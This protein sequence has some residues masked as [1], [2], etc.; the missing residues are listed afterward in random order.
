MTYRPRVPTPDVTKENQMHPQVQ[1][2]AASPPPASKFIAKTQYTN[3][4]GLT[5]TTVNPGY[6]SAS[7][8]QTPIYVKRNPNLNAPVNVNHA[9]QQQ[10]QPLPAAPAL[11]ADNV[12]LSNNNNNNNNVTKGNETPTPPPP[13]DQ[14]QSNSPNAMMLSTIAENDTSPYSTNSTMHTLNNSSAS[15]A[16]P[17]TTSIF[18]RKPSPPPLDELPPIPVVNMTSRHSSSNSSLKS[19]NN[20]LQR[21]AAPDTGIFIGV[22]Q[23]SGADMLGRVN[24]GYET[25]E[26]DD[27]RRYMTIA[28]VNECKAELERTLTVLPLN[29]NPPVV[30]KEPQRNPSDD[31]VPLPTEN[32]APPL[33]EV[34]PNPHRQGPL[35]IFRQDAVCLP[36]VGFEPSNLV[37]L[38][39]L[40]EAD[41][42]TASGSTTIF[43]ETSLGNEIITIQHKAICN[44]GK[45]EPDEDDGYHER[46]SYSE[47]DEV[48]NH[49]DKGGGGSPTDHG[50]RKISSTNNSVL[51]SEDLTSR[52]G[53]NDLSQQP[54]VLESSSSNSNQLRVDDFSLLPQNRDTLKSN[55]SDS[56]I[57]HISGFSVDQSLPAPTRQKP[58][59]RR[60]TEPIVPKSE[61]GE[62]NDQDETE[63]REKTKAKKD[64]EVFV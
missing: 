10:Q 42:T 20:S 3:G 40:P 27:G 12:S 39:V 43:T 29:P 60:K 48:S 57:S 58:I 44:S 24:E 31:L 45:T 1:I 6:G 19:E 36:D 16:Y 41:N 59:R 4:D 26:G 50:S 37:P 55:A 15:A 35:S 17:T 34:A 14:T 33:M 18:G 8:P 32:A 47:D 2:T 51:S 54:T 64:F 56:D 30:A 38:K 22:N 49:S 5:S 53:L 63:E 46:V 11:P 23:P 25:D 61:N 13:Y 21:S 62:S 28:E 52:R 7:T 9:L